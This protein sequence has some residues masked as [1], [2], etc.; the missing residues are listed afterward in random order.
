MVRA[1]TASEIEIRQTG[2]N[3]AQEK[4]NDTAGHNSPNVQITGRGNDLTLQAILQ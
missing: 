1:T 3:K 2:D 4:A